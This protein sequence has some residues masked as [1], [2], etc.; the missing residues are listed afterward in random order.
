MKASD[1]SDK[2]CANQDDG[3]VPTGAFYFPVET[4][5]QTRTFAFLLL[6]EFTLLAFSS[7]VEPLRIANQLAQ[8]PL[9]RWVILS[10]D[11][12][13]VRSSSGVEVGVDVPLAELDSDLHLLVC[14]GND[15]RSAASDKTLSALRIHTRMG[16]KAGG[17]CTG[18]VTL[19]RAGLLRD[20][21]FTL[22]WENQPAFEEFFPRLSPSRRRFEVD[23]S[24]Y[25]CG[26][27]A[28]ATDMML[29]AIAQDLGDDFAIAVSDMCLRGI[30]LETRPEQRSSI[31]TA[32]ATRDPRIVQ[33]V[34]EMHEILDDPLTFEQLA[35]NSGCSRRQM[36]R[37]FQKVLSLTPSEFYR[38]IRL[39]RA[40]SIF[41]QTDLA[42]SEVAV[43]CG[44]NTLG[45]FSK[46]YRARFGVSPSAYRNRHRKGA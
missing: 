11:G 15:G 21:R 26:G 32:I 33:I 39:D 3:H 2:K 22:H 7:A 4:G 31:A 41:G 5:E 16:G 28:A 25:T 38:N 12:F 42:V 36:E 29:W 1:T 17:I 13:P 20:R 14:S 19:A 27:G 30:G 35:Q 6:P 40:H 8:K 24:L 9:Y 10:E 37:S 45:V 43:A 34:R 18:A 23:G 44:F 46:H